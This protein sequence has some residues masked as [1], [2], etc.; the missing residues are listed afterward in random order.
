MCQS[1]VLLLL[2]FCYVHNLSSAVML[3]YGTSNQ[4]LCT[5]HLM[6]ELNI[7]STISTDVSMQLTYSVCFSTI[8]IISIGLQATVTA[9]SY[10]LSLSSTFTWVTDVSQM[11][12]TTVSV[13]GA[14]TVCIHPQL[15]GHTKLAT[16]NKGAQWARQKFITLK[17][18][19]ICTCKLAVSS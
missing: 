12:L 2:L 17:K 10:Q 14:R 18:R 4:L 16:S 8:T 7:K 1:A 15:P 11:H 5:F 3:L 6:D 19:N 9:A 13:Q